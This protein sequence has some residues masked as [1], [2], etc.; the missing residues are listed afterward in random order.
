MS[1]QG[2]SEQ[3]K[4]EISMNFSNEMEIPPHLVEQIKIDM[5]NFFRLLRKAE[6][7]L[8]K[9]NPPLFLFLGRGGRVISWVFEGWSEEVGVNLSHEVFF[10]GHEVSNEYEKKTGLAPE[11]TIQYGGEEG[12]KKFLEWLKGSEIFRNKREELEKIKAGLGKEIKEIVIVDD[13]C[14]SGATLISAVAL[15]A[16]VFGKKE[17]DQIPL[18]KFNEELKE[19][20]LVNDVGVLNLGEIRI[21]FLN[22][23]SDRDKLWYGKHLILNIFPQLE[24]MSESL[25]GRFMFVL[26]EI[27]KGKKEGEEWSREEIKDLLDRKGINA[28]QIGVSLEQLAGLYGKFKEKLEKIGKEI[29][30]GGREK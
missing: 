23:F 4:K 29:G 1:G 27:L 5:S 30:K 20:A 26:K 17:P 7:N 14:F 2:E 8:D 13:V 6:V 28:D 24:S 19:K 15:V 18:G 16:S 3:G 22:T 10:L 11:D 9:K 12:L 25:K 21:I